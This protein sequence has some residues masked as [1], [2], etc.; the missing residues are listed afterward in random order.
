MTNNVETRKKSKI[1]VFRAIVA[2][3]LALMTRSVFAGDPEGCLVCHRYRGLGRLDNDGKTI[4]LFYV[5]P[6]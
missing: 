1:V 3:F 2:I 6:T 5:D 4:K